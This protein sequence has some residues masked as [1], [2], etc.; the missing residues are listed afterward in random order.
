MSPLPKVESVG[1]G[2]RAH[3]HRSRSPVARATPDASTRGILEL[4]RFTEVDLTRWDRLSRDLDRLHSL[5]YFGFVEQRNA[6]RKE[7]LSA[8]QEPECAPFPFHNWA[9][10]IPYRYCLSPLSAEGSLRGVGGRFN[11]GKDV[12]THIATA[13]PALYLAEDFETAFREKYG[14]ERS[15]VSGALT[16]EELALQ[17]PENITSVMLRGSVQRAFDLT[18]LKTLKPFCDVLAKCK[19]PKEVAEILRRLKIDRKKVTVVKT[20]AQLC[21]SVMAHNWR[22]WPVQFEVP[23]HGQ[24]LASLLVAAGYEAVLYQSSKSG[25]RCLAVFPCNLGSRETYIELMPDYPEQVEC[26]RLDMDSAPELSG[27]PRTA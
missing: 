17:K 26:A 14:C 20:P 4:E 12:P 23:A 21:K 7:L 11:I 22:Q 3:K 16:P 24:I 18:N 15:D 9:R 1:T 25:R 10:I 6:L 5:L 2:R 13:W 8:L 27:I 19:M